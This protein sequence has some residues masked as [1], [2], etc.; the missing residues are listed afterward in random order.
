MNNSS[1]DT[2]RNRDFG[3]ANSQSLQLVNTCVNNLTM[4]CSAT[5]NLNMRNFEDVQKGLRSLKSSHSASNIAMTSVMASTEIIREMINGLQA[6]QDI[7]Q[8]L[9]IQQG[10]KVDSFL[11][12]L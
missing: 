2:D 8:M 5:H 6:S 12:D 1:R 9:N 4:A 7:S 10:D 3:L 11:A